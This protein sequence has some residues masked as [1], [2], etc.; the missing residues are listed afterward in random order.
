MGHVR[1]LWKSWIQYLFIFFTAV[2]SPLGR[3]KE[4]NKYQKLSQT[5]L[6]YKLLYI[7]DDGNFYFDAKIWKDPN[8]S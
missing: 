3:S 2:A 7:V 4:Y 5:E 6:C 1:K 8:D